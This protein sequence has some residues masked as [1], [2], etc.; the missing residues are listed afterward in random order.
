MHLSYGPMRL[1]LLRVAQAGNN[2]ETRQRGNYPE[3]MDMLPR[4]LPGQGIPF[5]TGAEPHAGYQIRGLRRR[6]Q[7]LVPR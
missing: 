5:P 4:P 6:N 2:F 1:P 7:N 3:G